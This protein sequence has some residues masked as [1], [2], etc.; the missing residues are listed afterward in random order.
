MLVLTAAFA[1]FAGAA[2]QAVNFDVAVGASGLNYT[3]SNVT[4]AVGD[5]VTFTL[6]VRYIYLLNPLAHFAFHFIVAKA[7]P[8][9][10]PS[11]A[12]PPPALLFP[13]V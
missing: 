11:R 10:S 5:T 9:P 12:L 4:A 3:P 1:L 13:A 8:I 7:V 2:V 6:Y